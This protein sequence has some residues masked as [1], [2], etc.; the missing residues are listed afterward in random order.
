MRPRIE[1]LLHRLLAPL[2]RIASI[3]VLALSTGCQKCP[4]RAKTSAAAPPSLSW[5]AQPLKERCSVPSHGRSAKEA[6]V[7]LGPEAVP[8]LGEALKDQKTEIRQAAAEVLGKMGADARDVIPMLA[9]AA[10]DPIVMYNHGPG[11][12]RPVNNSAG[13]AWTG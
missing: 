10:E 3:T 4:A 2:T 11:G 12:P 1:K 8:T 5:T 7:L 13:T 6:L 9:S